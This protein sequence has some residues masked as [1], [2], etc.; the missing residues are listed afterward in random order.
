MTRKLGLILVLIALLFAFV[1]ASSC[2]VVTKGQASK[3][4]A[5][6]WSEFLK[7]HDL[8][9]CSEILKINVYW[10]IQIKDFY[11]ADNIRYV[12]W[13]NKINIIENAQ[14]ECY[15][16]IDLQKYRN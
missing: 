4:A 7:A 2:T 5:E 11:S 13:Q 10:L 14:E 8:K 6:T 3:N 1:G 15:S 12:D 16:N 9:S